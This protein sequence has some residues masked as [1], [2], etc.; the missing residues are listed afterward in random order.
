ME[1]GEFTLSVIASLLA[2]VI[3]ERI[4]SQGLGYFDRRKIDRRIEDATAEVVE[5]L[6]PFLN[7]EKISEDKQR[8]LIETCVEELRPLTETPE[9]LFQ[10]SLN[11][12]KIFDELYAE[13]DLPQVVVE[14][15]VKDIYTLL[16]PR[17][18]AILCKI[19][20]AVRD[21][22]L[23]AWKED[24][25]RLDEVVAELRN[26]YSK[27]DELQ[28]SSSR[29]ADELLT[30][31]RRTLAQ[32]IEFELDL[33]GLRADKPHAGKFDDFFVHPEIRESKEDNQEQLQAKLTDETDSFDEFTA[34]ENRSIV[35]GQPGAGKS[36]W[37][38]W[39]QRKA[40][41]TE[42]EG[43]CVR[44]ELRRF[45]NES[46]PSLHNLI[47][48]V[49][50]QHL[51][52]NLTEDRISEWLRK[53]K[54]IFIFDG[55]DEI[56]QDDRDNIYDW[57]TELSPAVEECPIILTSRPV[58]TNHLE[59]LGETWSSWKI[60]PFNEERIIDYIQRWYA[61]K[62]L[63]VEAN[64]Q[65]D[66]R[67]LANNWLKDPTI[68]PLTGNPL[69]LSTLLMVHHLDG[70]LPS[71]RSE[72]YRRYVNGMLGLWD[73][74]RQVIA[75]NINLSLDQ[76]Q[77][78]M[79]GFALKM[80][81]QQKD[82]I[83]EYVALILIK[84]SLQELKLSHS[85]EK[86]LAILRE[87]SGLII[88]PG[89]Y[90]FVH[91]SVLEYLVA[92]CVL[93]GD[94]RDLLRKRIDRLCLF[95]HRDND[96][97][98]TI[99]FLWAGLA[100]LADVES[101]I[102]ECLNVGSWDLGYGI[103]YDQYTRFTPEICRC[104]LLKI[105]EADQ[106]LIEYEEEVYLR[107]PCTY[108]G[109][110][111]I[112]IKVSIFFLRGLITT[113][114]AFNT[115]INYAIRDGILKWSDRENS[116]GKIRDLLWLC[117]A[118]TPENIEEWKACLT[119]PGPDSATEKQWLFW[120][121]SNSF[122]KVFFQKNNIN[123]DEVVAAYKEALPHL[124]GLVPI[125]LVSTVYEYICTRRFILIEDK[126]EK[127]QTNSLIA[128]LS[129]LFKI[130]PN[131]GNGEIDQ[132]LLIGTC[133]WQNIYFDS[134]CQDLLMK[135]IEEMEQLVKEGYLEQ[136]ETYEN[137]INFVKELQKKRDALVATTEVES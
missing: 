101:F 13:R 28:T 106:N 10:G 54:V 134:K 111:R 9:R 133:K 20:A 2:S 81:L 24:F 131:S 12:Q 99:I 114:P 132:E 36:T 25:S 15:G 94:Q 130:L 69:L 78:I 53:R 65:V 90:S 109:N 72:L 5:P 107:F 27:V 122:Q 64:N 3:D 97:W 118:T 32:K 41:S 22:E 127:D 55:F 1:L 16:C 121:A 87:R 137:A 117:F 116:V 40:I 30:K 11:G 136:D 67:K 88:G 129:E 56:R 34:T 35:F 51:A 71:G 4:K 52:E 49:A 96:R 80:F 120:I 21:W 92:E 26:L 23:E 113:T 14:D 45:A 104:L 43:I 100:P 73:N 42:W 46:L 59:W 115:L 84:E 44:V 75:T 18:A 63:S 58:T 60:E 8:H 128:G 47:R 19:P 102:E 79:R 126:N 125:A 76:K 29:K 86:I 7:N 83:D 57:I 48:E 68:E 66:P 38:K 33:T 105:I 108:I 50:G 95:Q 98:N 103:L 61:H 110:K 31:V 77:K 135:F 70:D 6:L 119:S 85:E 112:D 89:I 37:A 123:L 17:I 93:Q 82:Q 39:L 91:K 74:R 62:P 124:C